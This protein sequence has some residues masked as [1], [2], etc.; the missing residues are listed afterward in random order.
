MGESDV[1]TQELEWRADGAQPRDLSSY[2]GWRDEIDASVLYALE[3]YVFYLVGQTNG[4][5]DALSITAANAAFEI[6]NVQHSER[7]IL[8]EQVRTIHHEFM[9]VQRRKRKRAPIRKAGRRG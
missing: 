8:F 1:V 4:M 2:T 7:H 6:D 9:K 3:F 5:N